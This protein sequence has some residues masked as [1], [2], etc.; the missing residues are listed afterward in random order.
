M[1]CRLP[2]TAHPPLWNDQGQLPLEKIVY[3]RVRVLL[4]KQVLDKQTVFVLC[5][6]DDN[7]LSVKT[8]DLTMSP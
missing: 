2:S 4:I 5:Y 3:V 8:D 1:I 6:F 7:N